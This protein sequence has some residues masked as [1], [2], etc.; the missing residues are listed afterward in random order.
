MSANF[1]RVRVR[2]PGLFCPLRSNAVPAIICDNCPLPSNEAEGS[3]RIT[4]PVSIFFVAQVTVKFVYTSR[5]LGFKTNKPA[6]TI[7][8]RIQNET[9]SIVSGTRLAGLP[10]CGVVHCVSCQFHFTDN[11]DFILRDDAPFITAGDLCSEFHDTLCTLQ[12]HN[13]YG[14]TH[15]CR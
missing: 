9:A 7:H 12:T 3:V 1:P 14:P 5:I 11:G 6:I 13:L 10:Q 8:F 2:Q 15:S 4:S